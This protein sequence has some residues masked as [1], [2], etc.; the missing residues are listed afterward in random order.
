MQNIRVCLSTQWD[1]TRSHHVRKENSTRSIKSLINMMHC[2]DEQKIVCYRGLIIYFRWWKQ[3][4][5]YNIN[6]GRKVIEIAIKRFQ[7][8]YIYK[9]RLYEKCAVT[10]KIC[11]LNNLEDVIFK[12]FPL[13]ATYS[14]FNTSVNC[15]AELLKVTRK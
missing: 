12:M 8:E 7:T 14:I 1:Q 11:A 15:I 6:M 9:Q 3:Y 13:R 5:S 2:F 10:W 4:S